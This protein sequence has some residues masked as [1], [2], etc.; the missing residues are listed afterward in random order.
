MNQMVNAYA[1]HQ[2]VQIDGREV[3]KRALLN[4][5]ARLKIALDD[6]GKDMKMYQEA[7]RHNQHLWT[8]FQVALVDPSNPLKQETKIGLLRLSGYIDRVSFRAVTEYL[9]EALESLITIN[10]TVAAGLAKQI[11]AA[12]S[13]AAA[14]QA[15][16]QQQPQPPA[17]GQPLAF[18]IS[19]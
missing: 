14:P 4:C 8:L 15:Q 1:A 12:Q 11:Q 18:S 2:N 6:G 19:T 9:P 5:A 7:I 3:D 13:Q 10:R 16:P 17:S